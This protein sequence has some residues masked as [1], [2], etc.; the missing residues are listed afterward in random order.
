MH[1]LLSLDL[2][3][4]GIAAIVQGLTVG[5]S[6]ATALA[7]PPLAPRVIALFETA[8]VSRQRQ[9]QLEASQA[10]KLRAL[11]QMASG[12]AHDLNQS[13]GIIA[14]YSDLALQV[15]DD[16]D[17]D[18]AAMRDNLG[19]IARAAQDGGDTVK[20]LL[21]FARGAPEGEPELVDVAALLR[22]VAKLTAPRWRD[23]AQRE[24]RPIEVEVTSDADLT[25][26]AW[27]GALREAIMNLV[28]NA[29]DAL[30]QG[31]AITLSVG[32]CTEGVEI[33]V[34]DTGLGIPHELQATIFEPFFTTKGERGTGL[35]LAMVFGIVERHGGSVAVTSA[36]GR[37][38]RFA[39][40]LPSGPQ[41]GQKSALPDA[42]PPAQLRVL[43]VDD[44]PAL[45]TLAASFLRGDGHLVVTASSGENAVTRLAEGTFDLVVSDLG[46]GT[47]MSGWELAERV[48]DGYPD[49]RFIMAT[50]WGAAIDPEEARTRGVDGILAK[51]Y[52]AAQL[53]TLVA[54]VTDPERTPASRAHIL[55]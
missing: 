43:A 38:S 5:A 26:M 22:D 31:G 47:G 34:S 6:V 46:L 35:G 49:T 4:Y 30:P 51:P 40:R 23:A 13:L 32:P 17:V 39:I 16:P 45:V 8:R 36:P 55:T 21:T 19:L 11:G 44:E 2:P 53:R 27:P 48:R 24:G 52:R 25:V 37:G 18:L 15:L 41:P 12:V 10:E 54:T 20:R 28:F 3:V 29:I 42:R 14:G 7:L 9:K 33:G 1:V 50:G